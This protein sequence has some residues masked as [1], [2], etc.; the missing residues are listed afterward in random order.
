MRTRDGRPRPHPT[1][2]LR[3]EASRTG[4]IVQ[5]IWVRVTV[6]VLSGRSEADHRRHTP[7]VDSI[8]CSSELTETRP[9]THEEKPGGCFIPDPAPRR[10]S[11]SAGYALCH[12]KCQGE[13][14]R[15]SYDVTLVIWFR[16]K[17]VTHEIPSPPHPNHSVRHA[18][19]PICDQDYHQICGTGS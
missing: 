14:S 4:R 8:P 10:S 17:G 1:S 5:R 13:H 18:T 16:Y 2:L 7:V 12:G 6:V 11:T 3:K 15:S 19:S 9:V